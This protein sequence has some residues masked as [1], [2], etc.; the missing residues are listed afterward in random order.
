MTNEHFIQLRYI[1]VKKVTFDK[2]I[3][4]QIYRYRF[5]LDEQVQLD[6]IVTQQTLIDMSLGHIILLPIQPVFVDTS[7]DYTRN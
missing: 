6:C 1:M 3:H 7:Y 4:I 5:V 2:M